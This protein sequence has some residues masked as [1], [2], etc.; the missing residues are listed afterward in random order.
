MG[1]GLGLVLG[2]WVQAEGRGQGD[3][4]CGSWGGTPPIQRLASGLGCQAGMP[5]NRS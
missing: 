1:W 3:G 4:V 5:R 2:W